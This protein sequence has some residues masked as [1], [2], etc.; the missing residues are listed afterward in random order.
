MKKLYIILLTLLAFT[1]K[2]YAYGYDLSVTSNTVSVGNS[3][4]LNISAS[5]AAGKFAISSSNPGVVSVSTSSAWLDNNTQS[6]TLKA[7]KEGTATISVTA[8]DVTSYSGASVTGTKSVTITVK[9]N[10][11]PKSSGGGSN[12]TYTAP[13]SSNNFL[14]SLTVDNYKINEPF[15]KENLE[16]T[17][18]VPADTE[19]IKINAQLADS[20]A[21][22]TGTGEV[23]LETG[24]NN[25]EIIVTAANGSKRTYKLNVTVEE[26]K[27]ITVKIDK[28]EY[29]VVRKRK[30]LPKISEYFEEKEVTINGETIEGYYNKKLGYTIVGL[31]DKKGN[32]ELYIYKN[33]KYT[34][35]KEYSF[36]GTVLQILDKALKKGFKRTNF[37]YDND[38]IPSYQE[39]KLNIIK[40]TYALDN[41]DIT[42]NQFYLFY[43]KNI[44]TG[45]TSLYQYDA[46]EKTVQRYNLEVLDMYKNNSATYYKCLLIC[47]AVIVVLIVTI[48][49]ILLTKN[50]KNKEVKKAKKE[51]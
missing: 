13:K 19:K 48:I 33:N 34:L 26:A 8:T 2:V 36:N 32:A 3:I 44:E 39:V 37:I 42:G 35:Y 43:A 17:L 18:T 11:A 49:T 45:K 38:K 15:D 21:S 1:T 27:P 28:V 51:A 24:I 40:N 20:T 16:Y 31:K 6:V 12:N 30:D 22:L 5:D 47:I 7:N 23:K 41:N 10:S 25:L 29:T 46:S 9:A 4:S 50:K 14:S